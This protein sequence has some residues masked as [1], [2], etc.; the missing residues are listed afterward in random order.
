MISDIC[1]LF[2]FESESVGCFRKVP[3]QWQQKLSPSSGWRETGLV[4]LL[5]LVLELEMEEEVDEGE[6]CSQT[7]QWKQESN[8]CQCT[9]ELG[10]W[11]WV[12]EV[13]VGQGEGEAHVGQAEEQVE[14]KDVGAE[15]IDAL[16]REFKWENIWFEQVPNCK[17]NKFRGW[18]NIGTT[19]GSALSFGILLSIFDV[20]SDF[21]T[22]W[23]FLK[24]DNYRKTVPS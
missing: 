14:V 12:G 10:C 24:G 16:W 20:S 22:F 11:C 9:V 1:C 7:Y 6:K 23:L 3:F 13:G 21:L 15:S 17:E 4:P 18:K 5:P 19:F 8:K 2:S